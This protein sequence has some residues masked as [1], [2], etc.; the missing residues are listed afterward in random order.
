VGQSSVRHISM[1]AVTY[2]SLIWASL[3]GSI[4]LGSILTGCGKHSEVQTSDTTNTNAA[5]SASSPTIPES[6][7]VA[8]G[9]VVQ[10]PST[11]VY[12]DAKK[13]SVHNLPDSVRPFVRQH[14]PGYTIVSATYD[15]LCG[16]KPAIDVAIKASGKTPYSVIFLPNGIYVQREQDV[17]LSSAPSKIQA[18]VKSQYAGFHPGKQIEELVLA[19]NSTQYA[20]DLAKPHDKREV[21]FS[22]DGV[23]LC[24]TKE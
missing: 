10:K 7:S 5:A 16:D 1:K 3:I 15:P 13:V 9:S 21:I 23:V 8:K 11:E 22:A 14:Y 4:L 12:F 17:P 20:V 24:E 6:T 2:L 19:D 18:T